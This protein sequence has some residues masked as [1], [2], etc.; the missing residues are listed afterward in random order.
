MFQNAVNSG[1]R[2]VEVAIL[3]KMD[4]KLT[5]SLDKQVIESAKKY[6]KSRKASLSKLIESYL[7][8]LTGKRSRE[9]N[10]SP[11]VASLTGVIPNDDKDHT[12]PDTSNRIRKSDPYGRVQIK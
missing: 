7:N 3:Y 5:L 11:L 2:Q 6:A 9:T 1:Q 8:S 10:V 12:R 4:A